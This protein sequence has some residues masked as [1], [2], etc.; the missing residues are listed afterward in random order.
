[1]IGVEHSAAQPFGDVKTWR[2]PSSH[3]PAGRRRRSPMRGPAANR[4]AARRGPSRGKIHSRLR[5]SNERMRAAKQLRSAPF[6]CYKRASVD[7]GESLILLENL[8]S[9]AQEQNP[10]APAIFFLCFPELAS[11][12]IADIWE[13]NANCGRT[14]A[15]TVSPSVAPACRFRCSGCAGTKPGTGADHLPPRSGSRESA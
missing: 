5:A 4:P 14:K 15:G 13:Q 8:A 2:V 7:P 12:D 9:V 1:M 6:A 3:H 10:G 11:A